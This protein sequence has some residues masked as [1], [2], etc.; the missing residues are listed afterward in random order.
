MSADVTQTLEKMKKVEIEVA[1]SLA[2]TANKA[3]NPFVKTLITSLVNDSKKH[4][5]ILQTLIDF[6]TGKIEKSFVDVGMGPR[7]K[8]SQALPSR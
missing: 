6:K 2:E 8:L 7:V 1:D 5:Q 3:T 4:A